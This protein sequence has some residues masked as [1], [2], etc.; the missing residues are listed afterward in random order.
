MTRAMEVLRAYSPLRTAVR[1]CSLAANT[2]LQAATPFV[3]AQHSHLRPEWCMQG[4][5][6]PLTITEHPAVSARPRRTTNCRLGAMTG[7][8]KRKANGMKYSRW[9]ESGP[10]KMNLHA[11]L[12]AVSAVATTG[13]YDNDR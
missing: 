4:I 7:R 2:A 9:C 6:G 8:C 13:T 5:V 1:N 11:R 10:M 3:K 12:A